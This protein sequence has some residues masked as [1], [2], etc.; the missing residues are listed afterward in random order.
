MQRGV[1]LKA[2]RET[3]LMTLLFAAGLFAF[4]SMLA[5]VMSSF[6]DDLVGTLMVNRFFQTIMQAMLGQDFGEGITRDAAA[7]FCWVHPLGLFVLCGYLM[8]Y[9]TRFPAGEIDRG[10][11]H[12]LLGQPVSRLSLV[13]G[14]TAVGLASLLLLL[15]FCT[16]AH[17]LGLLAYLPDAGAVLDVLPAVVAN[18]LALLLAV[19]GIACLISSVSRR[20]LAAIGGV[21]A[22]VEA[23]FLLNYLAPFWKMAE[24]LSF[25]G[26]LHYYRPLAIVRDG[27]WPVGDIAI[28]ST[29]G[30][31]FWAAG[32]LLFTRRNLA[33]N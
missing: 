31:L 5:Y 12:L 32:L 10:T 17:V 1:L 23:W 26:A 11:I 20:R 27:A 18:L 3:W 14:E 25:L 8:A 6:Y 7:A 24:S 15:G 30:L 33:P 9:C 4:H 29:I 13:L 16:V 19:G 2:I 21:F 28:L 22:V